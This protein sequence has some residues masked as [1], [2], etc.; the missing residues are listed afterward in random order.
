M[1]HALTSYSI[2]E[3]AN[4]TLRERGVASTWCV[5]AEGG[6]LISAHHGKREALNAVRR[7]KA[8]D[9]RRLT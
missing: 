7:Y 8:A 3:I 2:K 4:D 9:K 5:Y 1:A 6:V